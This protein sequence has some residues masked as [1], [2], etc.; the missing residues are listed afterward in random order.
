MYLCKQ[1]W[2]YSLNMQLLN[3]NCLK[4]ETLLLVL[5]GRKGGIATIGPVYIL[6]EKHNCYGWCVFSKRKFKKENLCK[7][8]CGTSFW[9]RPQYCPQYCLLWSL[10]LSR[11]RNRKMYRG[12]DNSLWQQPCRFSGNRNLKLQTVG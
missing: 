3:S 12:L 8:N 4:S 6:P 10:W 7:R 9:C 11:R 1:G 2:Q 5:F